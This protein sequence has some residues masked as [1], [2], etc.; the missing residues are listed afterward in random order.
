MRGDDGPAVGG[1][2]RVEEEGEGQ[3]EEEA[4]ED[5]G[6]LED[7]DDIHERGAVLSRR[8]AAWPFYEEV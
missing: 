1:G 4:E 3:L 7:V 6:R 2:E 8:A 5:G